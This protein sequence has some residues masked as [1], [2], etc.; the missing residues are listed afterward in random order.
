MNFNN[1]VTL[2]VNS[3]S[4]LNSSNFIFNKENLIKNYN[5]LSSSNSKTKEEK[6]LDS[7]ERINNYL[8]IK[9]KSYKVSSNYVEKDVNIIVPENINEINKFINLKNRVSN[10]KYT[11]N[12]NGVLIT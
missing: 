9:N 1:N 2:N 12:N 8:N 5:N 4:N 3:N 11:L 6:A 10:K 7:D